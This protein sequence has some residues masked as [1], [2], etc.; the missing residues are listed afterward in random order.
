M[1]FWHVCWDFNLISKV[2]SV[3]IDAGID[4]GASVVSYVVTY[5]DTYVGFRVSVSTIDPLQCDGGSVS[6]EMVFHLDT[7]FV[8]FL[9]ISV[10]IFSNNLTIEYG[11]CSVNM[12]CA[13]V[14]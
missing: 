7:E 4:A 12:S 9:I 2:L 13:C 6:E 11:N 3:V 14:G 1:I 8:F 5:M 10:F